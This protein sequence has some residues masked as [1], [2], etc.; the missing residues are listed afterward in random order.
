MLTWC[1]QADMMKAWAIYATPVCRDQTHAAGQGCS[2]V[3][4]DHGEISSVP[5]RQRRRY[6][7]A[8]E[9]ASIVN[10]F[11]TYLQLHHPLFC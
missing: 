8:G 4:V 10:H 11:A 6:S 1:A 3:D 5:G 2:T 7:C 9:F